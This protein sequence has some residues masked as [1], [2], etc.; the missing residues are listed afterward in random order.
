M[1]NTILDRITINP[2]IC[3]GKPTVRNM[4]ITVETI[5]D[6]LFGGD[7]IDEILEAYPFLQKEDIQACINYQ[8]IN[9][10]NLKKIKF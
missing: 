9:I 4:R 3:N 8:K 5:L 10:L 2:T 6:Y 1:D 7:A